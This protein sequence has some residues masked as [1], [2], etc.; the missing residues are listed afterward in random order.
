VI[1]RPAVDARAREIKDLVSGLVMAD[2]R[3]RRVGRAEHEASPSHRPGEPV[4][5][6][7]EASG[8]TTPR[9]RRRSGAVTAEGPEDGRRGAG[10]CGSIRHA[11]LFQ[12]RVRRDV[13]PPAGPQ[14]TQDDQGAR[15]QREH[16]QREARA[17]EQGLGGGRTGRRVIT[18]HP[19]GP[20]ATGALTGR[21]LRRFDV[22]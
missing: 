11:G 20:T 12:R 3:E 17:P 10:A 13:T 1:P 15:G 9:S 21:P 7:C 14:R 5:E 8:E 6:A 2:A 4:V 19:P 18:A 22:S 16:E